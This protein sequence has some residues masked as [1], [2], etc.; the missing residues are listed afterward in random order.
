MDSK[1]PRPSLLQRLALLLR[2]VLPPRFHTRR[3][4]L[5]RRLAELDPDQRERLRRN[6]RRLIHP[7]AA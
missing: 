1:S 6:L 5:H 7:K 4:R 2:R 3:M